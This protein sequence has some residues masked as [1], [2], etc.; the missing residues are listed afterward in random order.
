[1]R[2]E[3][4]I[5]IFR[6]E[7]FWVALLVSGLDRPLPCA[8]LV[9]AGWP[10][11][12]VLPPHGPDASIRSVTNWLLAAGARGVSAIVPKSDLSRVES[13]I[14]ECCE[15]SGLNEPEATGRVVM[16]TSTERSESIA[17][18]VY[19]AVVFAPIDP[20]YQGAGLE[21][22][23]FVVIMDPGVSTEDVLASLRSNTGRATSQGEESPK[24]P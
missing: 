3:T 6:I 2:Q 20:D 1:M 5:A 13:I 8:P 22:F 19:D 23:R 15:A 12:L 18:D 7:G 21:A 9:E 10:S 4:P 24:G 17:S 14:D 16:T 11:V